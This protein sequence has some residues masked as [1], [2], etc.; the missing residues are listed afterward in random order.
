MMHMSIWSC[1]LCSSN[2]LLLSCSL[3]KMDASEGGGSQSSEK[4]IRIYRCRREG[5]DAIFKN[6][7]GNRT[8][9]ENVSCS[10][11]DAALVTLA[12]R[13]ICPNAWCQ[14]NFSKVSNCD[15]HRRTCRR[16]VINNNC[17]I[18]HRHFQ[19]PSKLQKHQLVH[20]RKPWKC[21]ILQN[22]YKS[23]YQME[24]H[25]ARIHGR[26]SYGPTMSSA[27]TYITYNFD[28]PFITFWYEEMIQW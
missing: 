6:N 2:C 12:P 14:K 22:H 26:V 13:N 9:P 15:R 18:C 24:K 7:A 17:S 25:I 21:F 10:F 19:S 4:V 5:C 11:K 20:T 16:K 23:S 27:G 1:L 28:T 8:R 3:E